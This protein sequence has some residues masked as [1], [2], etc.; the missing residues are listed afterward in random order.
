MNEGFN[1]NPLLD[2]TV[3]WVKIHFKK[4]VLFSFSFAMTESG[5]GLEKTLEDKCKIIR[6]EQ[7]SR[8]ERKCSTSL[9][10]TGITLIKHDGAVFTCKLSSGALGNMKMEMKIRIILHKGDECFFFLLITNDL[11]HPYCLS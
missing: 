9:H 8:N 2:K 5:G 1:C 7:D 3:E 6:T 11:I 10:L 4:P